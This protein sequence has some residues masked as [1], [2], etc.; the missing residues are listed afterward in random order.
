M[1]HANVPRRDWG[2]GGGV[3]GMP[4]VG[5][6]PPVDYPGILSARPASRLPLFQSQEMMGDGIKGNDEG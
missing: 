2:S 5:Y 4:R 3:S 6:Q 1:C